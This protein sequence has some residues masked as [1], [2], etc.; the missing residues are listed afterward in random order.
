MRKEFSWNHDKLRHETRLRIVANQKKRAAAG[1][2]PW[3]TLRF[4]GTR[5]RLLLSWRGLRNFG[6]PVQIRSAAL[7]SQKLTLA[8]RTPQRPG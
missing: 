7:L 8:L 3:P 2:V 5:V 6:L 1:V 4:G